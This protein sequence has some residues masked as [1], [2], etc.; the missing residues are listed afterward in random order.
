MAVIIA[1]FLIAAVAVPVIFKPQLMKIAR[2]EV[3]SMLTAKVDFT[4]FRVSLIKGFPNLYVGMK[5]LSVV[6]T[7]SFTDDT[8]LAFNEFGLTVN[9]WSVIDLTTIEV[10]SILL[11]GANVKAHVLPNGN[12]NWDVMKPSETPETEV[13]DTAAASLGGIGIALR[14]F[15]IRNANIAYIDD[16]SD[17]KATV[18]NLNL[19]LSGNMA[20]SQTDLKLSTS[21][22]SINFWMEGIRYL[23]NATLG[24]DATLGANL[25]SS[26]YS[27]KENSF[28][29]NQLKLLFD[30]SI[31]MPGN[32]ID[33]NLNFKTPSTDFKTLLSMVP[34]IYM[35]DFE[36]L[37]TSGKLGL[38]GYIRGTYNDTQMPNAFI[39]LNVDNGM[40]KYP[41]LPK[42]VTDVNIATKVWFDG[43]N[44]DNTTVNVDRF[45]LSLGGNPFSM[46]MR[47]ATPISDMQVDGNI[48]GN[49]D[50][51]TLADVIHMDSTYMEGLL[52]TNL[53]F[54]GKLSFIEREQYERFKADGLIKLS[55]FKFKS[56]DLPAEVN[57]NDI[58]L[59]FTP[60][61]VNLANLDLTIASSDIHMNGRLE[62]FIPY[63]FKDSTLTGNLSVY[64]NHVDVNELLTGKSTPEE[65][66]ADSTAMSVIELPDNVSFDAK[67]DMKKIIYDKLIISDLTGNVNLTGGVATMKNLSM[68]MLDGYV[69]MAGFYDP[70]NIKSPLVNF[71]FDMQ[72]INIPTAFKSFTTLQKISPAVENMTGRVSTQLKLSSQLDTVMMP[73][74]NSI[75]A[76]GKLQSK[77]IGISNSKAFAKLADF[78]KKDEFRNP[79]LKDVNV[80]FSIKDGR[81]YIEPFDTR[82]AST[83]MN[84]G[85]DMGIDQTLNF[86]AKVSVPSSY[87]GGAADLANDLLGKYGAK[88]PPTIDVN[89][90]I[91][92]TSSKPDVQIDTGSGAAE[93]SPSA[94]QTAKEVAQEKIDEVK[95]ET[96]QKAKAEFDKL[97]ADA[98]KEAD[99]IRAEA[100]VQAEKIRKEAEV[101]ALKTEEEG[102]KKGP[103]AEKAAKEVAKK[104]RLNGEAAAQKVIT[105]A[106]AKANAIVEK[107]KAESAKLE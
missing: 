28:S 3:N 52:E 42:A 26:Y 86:K 47:V 37:Q 2:D 33:I 38:E 29:I 78:L 93:S 36:G 70:R 92:G 62:N 91:L 103:L 72:D 5:G 54:G 51:S 53:D 95:V 1:L 90:K 10:K 18:Q 106:D 74:L 101:Q 50:F 57:I 64:S 39:A 14:K 56:P 31:R 99:R 107:A 21:I 24:F 97:I 20:T 102:K 96:K 88:L 22:E 46:R 25:D 69:K 98:E 75:N 87:L 100:S 94:V 4:D 73:V 61:Y 71:D 65:E 66:V 16:S 48:T 89:L 11:D 84:F 23:K 44:M 81:I 63:V 41:D 83:K 27:F 60:R 17:M 8:L 7:D 105:E 76:Y 13:D 32:D 12:V 58:T 40:F 68:S 30:G 19:T 67:V 34:L 59:N 49:I 43:G 85:G 9:I 15:E 45:S 35:K 80:S 55:L 82:I 104:I 77:S 79:S 6:G